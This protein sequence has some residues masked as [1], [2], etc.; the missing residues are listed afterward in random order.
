MPESLLFSPISIRG[1]TARNRIAVAPMCQYSAHDGIAQDWHQIHYGKLAGGGA[2][3]VMLEAT[4]VE[5]R[6]RISYGDLGIW[7]D[8]QVG[9]LARVADLIRIGGAIPA[10]Q[11]AHAGRKGSCQRP[12][13][14]GGLVGNADISRGELPWTC[15]A[16]SALPA[17][18]GWPLPTEMSIKDIAQVR[19]AWVAAARRAL[20]AGFDIAEIHGAHGYLLHQ[21]LSPLMNQRN[22][23]YGGNLAGRMRLA[24]EVVESVRSVWPDDKPLFFRVSAIDGDEGG[25][26]LDD[27]V[28]LA[29]E[30]K[31]RGV[32]VVDCSSGGATGSPVLDSLKRRPSFQ[33]PF[34]GRVKRETGIMTMAVGLI[35]DPEQAEDALQSDQADLIALGRELLHNPH[36]PLHAALSLEGDEGYTLWPKQ[37][38]W[39]LS[40]RSNWISRYR[41]GEFS[42]E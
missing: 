40:R 12:W 37:Y 24:L 38:A 25:W 23:A 31:N 33:V 35:I 20:E 13:D 11:L 41:S 3:I 9:Q 4:A 15:I 6:G 16:P 2:G 8:T 17:A 18:E 22:D 28:V 39:S 14:G 21:F 34:A 10:I 42:D 1:V 29:A 26:S 7:N 36:W 5:A 30:L 19:K 27:T 32:D